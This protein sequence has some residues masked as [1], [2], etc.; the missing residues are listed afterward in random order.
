MKKTLL[1][2]ILTILFAY[3]G[4]SQDTLYLKD[5]SEVYGSVLNVGNGK[6][7]FENADTGD[8]K[9]YKKVDRVIDD[10][11]GVKVEFKKRDIDGLSKYLSGEIV[12]GKASYY[13]VFKYVSGQGVKDIHGNVKM[14]GYVAFY[15]IYKEGDK[16]AVKNLPNSLTTPFV[17]R[18]SKYFSDCPTL[19]EKMKNKEY[20]YYN[21][22]DIV[23]FYNSNCGG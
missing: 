21:S 1:T 11:D 18:M 14:G 3:S 8:R 16:K 10:T 17:K 22:K 15:Y 5:G 4:F 2:S 7:Y 9:R 12:K 23:E 20:S 13:V 19:V 6:V